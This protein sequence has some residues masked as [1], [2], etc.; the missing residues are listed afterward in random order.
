MMPAAMQSK[1]AQFLIILFFAG[2]VVLIG[3]HELHQR[4]AKSGRAKGAEAAQELIRNLHGEL[5]HMQVST[6]RVAREKND[7][8]A[9]PSNA[10]ESTGMFD[11][12]VKKLTP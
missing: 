11:Q 8:A 4:F 5:D 9:E 1:F 6:V 7:K 2:S 3:T 12:I 10:A